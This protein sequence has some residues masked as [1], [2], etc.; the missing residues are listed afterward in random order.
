[1]TKKKVEEKAPRK[2]NPNSLKN[3]SPCKPGENVNHKYELNDTKRRINPASAFISAEVNPFAIQ[4][5]ILSGDL[6]KMEEVGIFF[7]IEYEKDKEGN[8]TDKIKQYKKKGP[9]SLE[10]MLD[11]CRHIEPYLAAKTAQ[12]KPPKA[13]KPAKLPPPP[14][15]DDEDTGA[16]AVLEIPKGDYGV[17]PDQDEESN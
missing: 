12:Y 3:L 17:E 14:T 7:D 13:A 6:K 2:M 9:I 11:V 10:L 15:E 8:P 1:M 5:A 4:A 16:G